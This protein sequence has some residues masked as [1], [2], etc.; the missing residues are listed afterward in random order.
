MHISSKEW[1]STGRFSPASK[2]DLMMLSR[3]QFISQQIKIK[4]FVSIYVPTV[5]CIQKYIPMRNDD[6]IKM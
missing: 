4:V 5:Q 3:F 2:A 6:P 1:A